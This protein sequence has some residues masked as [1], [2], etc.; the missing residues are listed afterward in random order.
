M[1]FW[2]H[3]EFHICPYFDLKVSL[4]LKIFCIGLA[5]IKSTSFVTN[6]ESAWNVA[7]CYCKLRLITTFHMLSSDQNYINKLLQTQIR[8]VWDLNFWST[9]LQNEHSNGLEILKII[10]FWYMLNQCKV[11][12]DWHLTPIICQ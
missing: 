5:C 2:Y 7:S 12:F 1:Y 3:I 6:H 11:L 8:K 10:F 9:P 4:S